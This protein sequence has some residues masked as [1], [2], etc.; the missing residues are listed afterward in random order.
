VLAFRYRLS[1]RNT[2]HTVAQSIEIS[3]L[4]RCS[5]VARCSCVREPVVDEGVCRVR[6][7]A[8]GNKEGAAELV[9]EKRKLV[10]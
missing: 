6:L 2:S 9:Y 5:A 4:H 7:E 10:D 1:C 3:K 8:S